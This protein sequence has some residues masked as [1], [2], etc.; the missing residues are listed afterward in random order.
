VIDIGKQL[1]VIGSAASALEVVS[2]DEFLLFL[3]NFL[4]KEDIDLYINPERPLT[5]QL[6]E[7]LRRIALQRRYLAV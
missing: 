5:E 3:R 1:P 2:Q 7:D 4:N 6:L